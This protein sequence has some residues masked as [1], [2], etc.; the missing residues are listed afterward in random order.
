VRTRI[1]VLLTAAMTAAAAIAFAVAPTP[2]GA[3]AV[4][5]Q[6]FSGYST[7]T[8]VS[9]NALQLGDTAVGKVGAAFSGDS[10]NSQGLGTS[11]QDELGFAVQPP[12]GA[13]DAYGRGTGLE[14]G[15]VVPAA[16]QTDVNQLLLSGLAEA[17]APPPEGVPTPITKDIALNLPPI[18]TASLLRGQAQAIFDPNTCALGQPAAYGLGSASDLRLV[19][20]P[21]AALV[22]TV[23][24]GTGP[25]PNTV[26]SSQSFSY[27]I[28]N[29]DGS[30]GLV[31]ET[32]Q[33]IAPIAIG[34]TALGP[35][36]TIEAAGE[37]ILRATATGI[38]G[39]PRNGITYPGNPVITIR[40]PAGVQLFQLSL[41]D[42]LG[43]NGL[44]LDLSPIALL[45]LGQAPRAIG[46]APGSAP[47]VAADG[48][49]AA[50]AVDAVSS[51]GLLNL[52]GLSA[53]DLRLGHMEAKAT[54]PAGGIHCTIPVAKTGTPNPA[55]AGQDVTLTITFP[56]DP[57]LFKQLIACDLVNIKAT[58]VESVLSGN[59]RF[60]LV[61]ADHG[62]VVSG[63]NVTWD[64]LGSYHP[65][66][67]P[68]VLTVILHVDGG[69]GVLQDTANVTASL[70]NCTGGAANG[71]GVFGLGQFQNVG[72]TGAVTLRG[73]EVSGGN[74]A[75]T[76]SDT[77]YLVLG[78][79]LL[80]GAYEIRR[81]IRGRAVKSTTT[82]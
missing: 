28:P 36:L 69:T 43:T 12:L 26:S 79:F 66:D 8:V 3:Q 18:A 59:P 52:E 13:K 27:F 41:S 71:T 64:N 39:D 44:N 21:D 78:G 5:S 82:S 42:L 19:G 38:P 58:D 17:S 65:G 6:A 73:P 7:G 30:F 37:F 62:G 23:S 29:P 68:I 63:N 24:P 11:I 67:P 61:S 77:R 80:L 34:T 31:S 15:L 74:L 49:T 55:Q 14:A 40:G 56:P 2:A 60:H 75:A 32:H 25:A 72:V 57:A 1:S 22:G 70:A 46:G 47:T 76:G 20:A 50:A 33:I 10:L 16:Q 81:R 9:S 51:V 54:V 48:T 35:A 4:T 45:S 53:L